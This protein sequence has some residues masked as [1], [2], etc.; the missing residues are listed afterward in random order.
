VAF[1]SFFSHHAGRAIDP[2]AAMDDVI[3][4]HRLWSHNVAAENETAIH[5][6]LSLIF[7]HHEHLDG[8]QAPKVKL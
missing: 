4:Q 7:F 1:T 6:S 3:L 8:F 5:F 2:L